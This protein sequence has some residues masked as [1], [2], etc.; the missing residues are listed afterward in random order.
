[1]E[2]TNFWW[3]AMA[4]A[5]L[6]LVVLYFRDIYRSPLGI[7]FDHLL[8]WWVLGYR[9]LQRDHRSLSEVET[10]LLADW[11][12]AHGVLVGAVL[13]AVLFAFE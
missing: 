2:Q 7:A 4:T 3:I 1:M 11:S 5:F 12:I 10:N 6:G 13:I 9:L 8:S